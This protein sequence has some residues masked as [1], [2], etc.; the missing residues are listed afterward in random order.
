MDVLAPAEAPPTRSYGGPRRSGAPVRHGNH[1][2]DA[3]GEL[4]SLPLLEAT[5]H[6]AL[7]LVADDRHCHQELISA[8]EADIALMIAVLRQANRHESVQRGTV[9][10]V[11]DAV[12]V[13][14]AQSVHG[15]V[16]NASTFDFFESRTIWD[17]TVAGARLHAVATQHAASVIASRIGY[18]NRDR[19]MV[20]SLLH[21][22]GKLVLVRA[23]PGY[24]DDVHQ[25]ASTPEARVHRERI[26]FGIDHTLVGG[27]LARRWDFPTSI[28]GV[29]EHHHTPDSD[30]ESTIV[31]LADMLA[32]YQRGADISP[33]EIMAVAG[34]L[35]L[36]P[37]HLRQV[38]YE[39][40]E[41][42]AARER[43]PEPC[44][45]SARELD[46]LSRLATGKVSK[47]VAQDLG[48]SS[49]TVRTHLHNIN[50]KLG[51]HD[52]AHAVIHANQRGWLNVPWGGQPPPLESVVGGLSAARDQDDEA[53][54]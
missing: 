19:L 41:P 50:I 3:I 38:M 40:P 8:A 34:T 26:E 53:A 7:L 15:I 20:T 11:A 51:V 47:E 43:F 18:E 14:S 29:I 24:P 22:I 48:V 6:R 23:Y 35:G 31:R 1:L 37:Q 2:R 9:E 54:A 28:A 5:R 32:H 25:N 46:T 36:D 17:T 42:A 30:L 33:G 45:L 27:V 4:E 39:L 21:D 13:L 10:T 52:R 44:P 16:S 49:S 12:G